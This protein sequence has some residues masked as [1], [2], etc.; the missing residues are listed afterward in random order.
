[1]PQFTFDHGGIVRG[2]TAEKKIA[3][4]FTG[5]EF[6]EGTEHILDVLRR[7]GIRASFFVTGAYISQEAHHPLLRRMVR[8]GH[9]LGPH[10]HAHP[11]YAPWEDREQTLVSEEFFRADLERNMRDLERFGAR[12]DPP[13]Y[14][15]PPYEWFNED[16][17]RWARSMGLVLFNFTPGSGS[18]RDWAPEGH[19]S[20][21]P[22]QQILDDILAHEERDPHGLNGFLLLLHLGSARRDPF[23]PRLESLLT[24]L[25]RRGYTF[26]RVDEMLGSP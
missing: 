19:R 13:V 22:S 21:V 26:V 8:E 17:V 25:R 20:F 3:L 23:H 10:S 7:L 24:E 2:D 6:G 1:M 14:F 5:G 16:Q 4:V 18:N 12:F 11:L 9:L 15:I